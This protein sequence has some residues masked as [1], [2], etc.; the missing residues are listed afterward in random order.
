MPGEI[1][2][3]CTITLLCSSSPFK[4]LNLQPF[5]MSTTIPQG[6][7]QFSSDH[8][9]YKLSGGVSTWMGDRL[10]I[11]RVVDFSFSPLF[12]CPYMNFAFFYHK[13]GLLHSLQSAN[14]INTN[15]ESQKRG[16]KHEKITDKS[17]QDVYITFHSHAT[18]RWHAKWSL[19]TSNCLV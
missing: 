13:V 6:K 9:S 1:L 2:L 10:G 11:P 7:H 4:T 14:N 8:R 5:Q 19:M 17:S 12:V 15:G 16:P 18:E 3:V